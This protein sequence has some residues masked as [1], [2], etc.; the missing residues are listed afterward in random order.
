MSPSLTERSP[1]RTLGT[2]HI[3]AFALLFWL[4]TYA[5]LSWRT[6][7]LL[8]DGFP[9]IS[10]RRILGTSAGAAIYGLVLCWIERPVDDGSSRRPLAI[11]ATVLPASIAVLAARLAVDRL[12]YESAL[13][14]TVNLRWV[15]AWSG[16]FGMWVSFSLA[17]QM[18]RSVRARAHAPAIAHQPVALPAS[19]APRGAAWEWL[20]ETA[21]RELATTPE[22]ERSGLADRLVANAGCHI[23]E[24]LDDG[25]HNARVDLAWQIAARLRD[26]ERVGGAS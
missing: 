5:V 21:A 18:H 6:E 9:L 19:A 14:L 1:F 17:L 8:G 20:I 26:Q 10:P 15:L 13:P 23:A 4:F 2:S 22:T 24:D 11:V 16:Y 3:V 25:A 12:F 7:M